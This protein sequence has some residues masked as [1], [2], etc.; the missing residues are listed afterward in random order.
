MSLIRKIEDIKELQDIFTEIS[1]YDSCLICMHY[2]HPMGTAMQIDAHKGSHRFG[3]L[4]I[5]HMSISR[6]NS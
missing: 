5:P 6:K 1:G 3:P 4:V 2:G